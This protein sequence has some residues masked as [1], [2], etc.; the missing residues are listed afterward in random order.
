MSKTQGDSGSGGVPQQYQSIPLDETQQQGFGTKIEQIEPIVSGPPPQNAQE[1]QNI[2]E[3]LRSAISTPTPTT[4]IQQQSQQQQQQQMIMMPPQNVYQA[5]PQPSTIQHVIDP[6]IATAHFGG[7]PPTMEELYQFQQQNAPIR[8]TPQSPPPIPSPYTPYYNQQ[9]SQHISQTQPTK[10]LSIAELTFQE[11]RL[12]IIFMIIMIAFSHQTVNIFITRY[13][14]F[15]S[16][17]GTNELSFFGSCAKAVIAGLVL[18]IVIKFFDIDNS[19]GIQL[20]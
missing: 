16:I 8:I 7:R 17:E 14:P 2:L 19:G 11:L 20:F 5:P 15:L 6:T 12:P 9:T 3:F 13:I 10:N 18:Y 4:T 1:A